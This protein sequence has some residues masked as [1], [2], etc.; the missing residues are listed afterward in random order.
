M[1][2]T[3]AFL[4]AFSISLLALSAKA[5]REF[6]VASSAVQHSPYSITQ[7]LE[8]EQTLSDG[9]H[10][11]TKTERHLYRDSYGR[12]RFEITPPATQENGPAIIDIQDPVS[13]KGYMLNVHQKT[14]DVI[15]D[16]RPDFNNLPVQPPSPPPNA[17]PQNAR[18]QMSHEDLG[19]QT[20]AGL[21]AKGTRTTIT[22][23]TGQQGN[24][25]PIVT[26]RETWTSADLPVPVY[27]K[28]SDPRNG[29]TIT[30]LIS[31]D[32]S[33]PDPSLFQVPPDYVVREPNQR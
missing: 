12:T 15:K 24:D 6:G 25:R 32:R 2:R 20:I 5:Q 33:E 10:I 8:H 14:A 22:I 30:R 21:L 13:N 11:D 29:D 31:I 28:T 16:I 1:K 19:T 23:P 3:Q 26:V 7:E 27:S 4:L 9:T 17:P 18:P